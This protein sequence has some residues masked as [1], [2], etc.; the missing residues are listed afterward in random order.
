MLSSLLITQSPHDVGL[1]LNRLVKL[2]ELQPD[3]RL[4]GAPPETP[5]ALY[6]LPPDQQQALLSFVRHYLGE[7]LAILRGQL[8]IATSAVQLLEKA[9]LLAR[10]DS[11]GRSVEELSRE[12]DATLD[13]IS[14]PHVAGHTFFAMVCLLS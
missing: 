5:S 7:R 8:E 3:L 14:P 10:T 4:P 11:S 6:F 9:E 2:G 1:C 12:L 13:M